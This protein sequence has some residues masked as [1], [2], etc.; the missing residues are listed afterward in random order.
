MHYT[1]IKGIVRQQL[2]TQ[3]PNAKRPDRHD[4]EEG[5]LSTQLTI[6]P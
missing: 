3:H 5:P 4:T 1:K 6:L 2:K